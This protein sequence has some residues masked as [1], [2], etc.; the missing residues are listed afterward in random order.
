MEWVSAARQ[1]SKTENEYREVLGQAPD[2]PTAL[3]QLGICGAR[4]RPSFRVEPR[5]VNVLARPKT[6]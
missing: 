6:G 2:D 4:T 1:D 3:R 5:A